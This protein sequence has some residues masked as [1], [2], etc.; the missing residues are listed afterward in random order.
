MAGLA[1]VRVIQ[2]TDGD[3]LIVDLPRGDGEGNLRVRLYGIDAP[4]VHP[5]K[6][7]FGPEA[8][9]HLQQLVDA[10]GGYVYLQKKTVDKYKRAVALVFV[11]EIPVVGEDGGFASRQKDASLDMIEKGLAWAYRKYLTDDQDR[12]NLY[13]RAEEKARERRLGIWST[14]DRI[15]PEEFRKKAKKK[16]KKKEGSLSSISAHVGGRGDDSPFDRGSQF[17][18][19]E[20]L[21]QPGGHQAQTVDRYDVWSGS[22]SYVGGTPYAQTS[23]YGIY[24]DG[25]PQGGQTASDSQT[26]LRRGIEERSAV[27]Y[28]G[29]S[30]GRAE[31]GGRYYDADEEEDAV[32]STRWIFNKMTCNYRTRQRVFKNIY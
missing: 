3:T 27:G 28:Q 10:S 29:V 13:V 18:S 20:L 12:R 2:V 16:S 25:G 21:P 24:A 11:D 7:N 22:S 14:E 1:R 19:F 6:Q 30:Q 5:Y 17:Y 8:T 23:S 9:D 15:T 4:E 31:V 32:C 26:P